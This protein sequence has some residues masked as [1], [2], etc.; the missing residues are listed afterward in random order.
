LHNYLD[1]YTRWAGQL[2]SAKPNLGARLLRKWGWQIALNLLLIAAVFIAAAFVK[3]RAGGWLSFIPA[4]E[5]GARATLWLAAMIVCL[6]MLIAV[7]RKLQ[8]AGMLVS[9]MSIPRDQAGEGPAALR[10]VVSSAVLIAGCIALLLFILLLS[11]AILPSWNVLVVLAVVLVAAAIFLR[12]PF[13]QI[14]AK[15]QVALSETLSDS[16]AEPLPAEPA[17]HPAG[18]A[19]AE[20]DH[21]A[22][23]TSSTAVGRLIG[24]L[25][26]RTV[27]GASIVG[28]TRAGENIINPGPDEEI[29]A[30]DRMVLLGSS[31]QL[32][33]AKAFLYGATP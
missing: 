22:V 29:Q 25:R 11:S 20:L 6:P 24:E 28:I 26:L 32:A 33:A 16:P 2:G 9:E 3:G 10:T 4:G 1:A 23:E 17:P 12:R 8:A 19:G 27:T 30:G 5:N 15:A 14:H 7:F 13:I 31:P 21:V 18:L